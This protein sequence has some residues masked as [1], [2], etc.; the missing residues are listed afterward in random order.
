MSNVELTP[1]EE[2]LMKSMVPSYGA[3]SSDE[4]MSLFAFLNKV[5]Q[6][7]DTT[8]LGYLK[9][10]EIGLPKYPI[11][12]FKRL[13]LISD[14]V[15]ENQMFKEFFEQQSEIITSTSLSRDAKLLNMAIIQ[16]KQLED[17]TKPKKENKS[18]FKK[19][20]DNEGKELSG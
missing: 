6:Q 1:E 14:K 18:W 2:E 5:I 11:R 4:K 8:K 7:D 3:V 10:E 20:D 13:A 15:I 17:V 9:E 16:R 19:K 12:T